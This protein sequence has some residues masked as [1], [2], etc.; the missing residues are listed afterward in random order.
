MPIQVDPIDRACPYPWTPELTQDRINQT[1]HK[2]FAG[3]KT[4]T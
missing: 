1:P 2:P 4:K 3:I